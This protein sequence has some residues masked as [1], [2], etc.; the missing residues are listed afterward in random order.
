M[1]AV[2]CISQPVPSR[3]ASEPDS[4][5]DEKTVTQGTAADAVTE[6]QHAVGYPMKLRTQ[7]PL[8]IS[9]VILLD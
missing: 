8:P 3:A 6:L 1:Q 9:N 7:H 5:V 2:P 4:R